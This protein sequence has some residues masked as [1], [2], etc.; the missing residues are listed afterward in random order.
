[1]MLV[2]RVSRFHVAAKALAAAAKV[3]SKV[4]TVAHEKRTYFM[5][6]AEKEKDYAYENDKG[7]LDL[8]F[9]DSVDGSLIVFYL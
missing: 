7:V 4:A 6:L 3:N 1:M 5:H 2:N 9:F 8:D